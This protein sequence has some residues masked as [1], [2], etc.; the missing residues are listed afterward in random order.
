MDYMSG[1]SPASLVQPDR[2]DKPNKPITRGIKLG[3]VL[4]AGVLV[5][6]RTGHG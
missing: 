5:L 4:V 1:T 6:D 2:Q 3:G